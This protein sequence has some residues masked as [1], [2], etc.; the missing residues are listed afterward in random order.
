MAVKPLFVEEKSTVLDPDSFDGSFTYTCS[1]CGKRNILQ[2]EFYSGLTHKYFTGNQGVLNYCK[3][4]VD[5]IFNGFKKTMKN[6][7][8]AV[9]LTC[10]VI[11]IFWSEAIYVRAIERSRQFTMADYLYIIRGSTY[12]DKCFA[13]SVASMYKHNKNIVSDKKAVAIDE[14]EKFTAEEI[15]NKQSVI[16]VVGH[17]PYLGYPIDD[18]KYLFSELVKYLD[19]SADDP[20]KLSIL[21]Q[22][23]DEMNQVRKINAEIAMI[24]ISSA[25]S[26]DIEKLKSLNF[27]KKDIYSNIDKIA[28]ENEISLKN[29]SNKEI[30]KNTLTVLMKKLRELDFEKAEEDYYAQLKSKAT[31]WATEMSMQAISENAYFDENDIREIGDIR[32][33][34]V[35]KLQNENDEL[36]EK[37][38]LLHKEIQELK[39]SLSDNNV[40]D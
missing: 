39:N 5:E 4:C 30:G 18:R 37:N 29:R 16:E 8:V 19:E 21:I 24:N 3:G 31:R 35:D 2:K 7:K 34:I 13:D 12:T 1:Q 27:M 28:K 40:V 38:R 20:Y 23:C 33:E 36:K 22:I 10:S 15:E 11:G 9:M 26:T 25:K 32:R 17:D 14:D 6:E